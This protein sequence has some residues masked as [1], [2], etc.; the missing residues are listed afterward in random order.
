MCAS[1]F[2]HSGKGGVCVKSSDGPIIRLSYH[3]FLWEERKEG[4]R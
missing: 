4:E 3:K 1:V 2:F